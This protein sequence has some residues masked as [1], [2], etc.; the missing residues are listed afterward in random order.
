MAKPKIDPVEGKSEIPEETFESLDVSKIKV[1]VLPDAVAKV[2]RPFDGYPVKKIKIP[3]EERDKAGK[4]AM[5]PKEFVLTH[6]VLHNHIADPIH[7]D[8]SN[9]RTKTYHSRSVMDILG[10]NNVPNVSIQF[11]TPVE[12]ASGMFYGALVPDPYIRAQLI[13]KRDSKSGSVLVDKR[14]M[15]LD[16]DQSNKLKQCYFQLIKP[17]LEMEKAADQITAGEDL[18]APIREV[19]EGEDL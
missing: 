15:L 19:A 16:T 8:P 2:A 4:K 11:S 14:Y 17:Q 1:G 3:M 5:I 13:F 10:G 6:W 18:T 12:T 7:Q 9:R